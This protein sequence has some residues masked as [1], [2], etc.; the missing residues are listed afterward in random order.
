MRALMKLCLLLSVLYVSSVLANQVIEK[1]YLKLD[2]PTKENYGIYLEFVRE[3]EKGNT[4]AM[5]SLFKYYRSPLE[6]YYRTKLTYDLFGIFAK[7]PYF[8]IKSSDEFFKSE[9]CSYASLLTEAEENKMYQ[10]EYVLEHAS[11][12]ALSK[13]YLERFKK[14]Q[15]LKLDDLKKE[16]TVCF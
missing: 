9:I 10:V 14:F 3:A 4:K 1:N 12:K 5:Q 7:N 15:K 13:K 8:Y 11:D 6:S 16:R 2:K